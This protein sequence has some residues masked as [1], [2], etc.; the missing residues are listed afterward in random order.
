VAVKDIPDENDALLES[1]IHEKVHAWFATAGKLRFTP[2]H[3][4]L[5]CADVALAG[6][7]T[8]RL[9]FYRAMAGDTS[10]LRLSPLD[11][12]RLGVAVLE[13]LVV[14]HANKTLHVDIKPHNVLYSMEGSR[15][16]F[17]LGD[18]GL[19]APASETLMGLS[20]GGSPSGTDGY[21]SP[22]LLRDDYENGVYPRFEI[23]ANAVGL[24][25]K[26]GLDM[27]FAE[28]RAALVK[29]PESPGIYKV[30]LHSLALTLLALLRWTVARTPEAALEANPELTS[31]IARL[32]FFRKR[33]FTTALQALSAA[34]RLCQTLSTRE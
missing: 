25:R 9:V 4:L 18:F 13:S 8:H 17:V 12:A 11:V 26:S 30:D 3:P 23:V 6:G 10:M 21:I 5:N 7:R 14:L 24:S 1:M 20:K 15:Y 33:D 16:V 32:M 19:M 31:L 29:A 27:M 22:L 2:L 28:R 34:K